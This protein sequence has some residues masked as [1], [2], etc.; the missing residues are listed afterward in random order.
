MPRAIFQAKR[1]TE[2]DFCGGGAG[3]AQLTNHV[4]MGTQLVAWA[5]GIRMLCVV[6]MGGFYRPFPPTSKNAR[7]RNET[8]MYIKHICKGQ[9]RRPFSWKV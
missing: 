3:G 6:V 7:L 4:A 1:S 9:Y 2:D 8:M 5:T